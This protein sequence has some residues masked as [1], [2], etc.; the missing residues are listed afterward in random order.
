M[1]PELLEALILTCLIAAN[2]FFS[3]AEFA[4][5]SSNATRLHELRE[6]GN[7]SA[8]TALRLLENPG[9]FLS[10]I[11]VGIT[12]I[13]TFAGA[14][15]GLAFAGPVAAMI[16]GVPSLAAYAGELAVATVVIGVTF[17]T[18]VIG[19]LA[20][21]KIA[22]QHPERIALKIAGAIDMLCRFSAPAITLI[23]GTTNLVLKAIGI[24]SSEKPLVSDED[25]ML[26]IRQGAKKGIFES[27]EYDM[28]SRIFRL[29][30][31]RASAMMTPRSETDWLDLEK[32]DGELTATIMASGRSRFPVGAGS[33]D[34]LMGV[35]RSV[36]L[37]SFELSGRGGMR[38]A[39]R[40][41][42]KPPLFVPESV[43]AFHVLELFR[44]NRVHMAL[45]IDE[46]GSVEG[47]ITLTDVLES[48]VGDVPADDLEREEKRILRRSNRTW[49]IDGLL[50]VDEFL[51]TFSLEADDFSGDKEAPY[52]TMGGFMMTRLGEV[53]AVS[54]T[55]RWHNIQFRVIKMNGQRVGRILVEFDNET[56]EKINR[57]TGQTGLQ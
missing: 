47:T 14:F 44:K 42:M 54:D 12:L 38:E 49:I 26:L 17:F 37:V 48:I 29:S 28:V 36:D 45:V 1:P 22:L 56:S 33:L 30:D 23:N 25:V 51:S 11:Q 4:I 18:L 7:L 6:A 8:G 55:L 5:I 40:A 32:S 57:Q 16:A 46:H 15:S 24:E 39:I 10:A 53:P 35:V 3:M 52:E 43:P 21:K 50:P 13:S 20:P 34:H 9:R 27:V 2:G 31:K 41:S 19:E